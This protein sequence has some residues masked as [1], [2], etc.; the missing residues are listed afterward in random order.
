MKKGLKK[1]MVLAMSLSLVGGLALTA[2]ASENGNAQNGSALRQ[3]IMAGQQ[4]A[5]TA[6]RAVADLTG[7]SVDD[8]RG[9]RTEGNS[10]AA[11]AEAKG[12]SE[13]QVIDKVVAE[14]IATLEQLKADNKITA[15]QYQNCVDNMEQRIKANIER[16]N[17]G[18]ANGNQA[19]QGLGRSQGAGKGQG[20]GQGMSRGSG[21]QAN[22]PFNTDK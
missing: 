8:I 15:E 20:M 12:V 1:A 19:G 21:N 17:V 14:R 9:Q 10:L 3:C 2:T 18:P 16:T 22:C 5:Q 13:A 4:R 7:L 11:I 6:L